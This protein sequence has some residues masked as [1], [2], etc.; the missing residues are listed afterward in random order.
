[1]V[2]INNLRSAILAVA[3]IG[4]SSSVVSAEVRSGDSAAVSA[5]AVNVVVGETA[6]SIATGYPTAEPQQPVKGHV[7]RK[8]LERDPFTEQGALG[9]F[10]WGADLG[11]G[12]DL[13]AHDMTGFQISACFGYKG[14]WVRFA[15]LG[16]EL[17][18]MMNNSSRLTPVYAM[19]RTSFSPWHRLCFME[20]RAGI[21]MSSIH[22]FKTQTDLYGS[23]GLGL[24]LAHSRKFSSHVVLRATAVPLKP[25]TDNEG[26][27]QLNY[28]LAYAC[29]GLGCA[30]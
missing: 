21:S 30:F 16:V 9:H 23:L 17:M 13:T 24:T 3:L 7:T 27:R 18:S 15:G 22:Q 29:I 5:G 25:V 19:V 26:F 8:G 20:L 28:V 6:V 1:M 4:A 14:R 2:I 12:V 11:S 10:T